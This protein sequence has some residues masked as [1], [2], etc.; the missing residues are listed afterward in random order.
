MKRKVIVLLADGS[1]ETE[2]VFCIDLLRRAGLDVIVASLGNKDIVLCSR[3]VKIQAD[4]ELSDLKDL[5]D[6]IVLP[7]G[8]KGAENLAN[9][10]EV[11]NLINRCFDK[12]KIVAAICASPAVVLSKT[13]VLD[14]KKATCYPGSQ[15]NFKDTTTYVDEEVVVDEN[16]ITSKGPGTAAYFALEII[17]HLRGENVADT[18][19]KKALIK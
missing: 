3:D 13:K 5:P 7:G 17:K 1:E 4:M 11:L 6:A 15:V 9:S 18:V 8:S 16:V 12:K 2:A 14:N 10:Q 19:K